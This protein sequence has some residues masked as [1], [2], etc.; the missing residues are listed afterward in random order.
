MAQVP[1]VTHYE[2]LD[3]PV[4]ADA[5]E[6]KKAYQKS[7]RSSHPD[8]GGSAGL[9]RLVKEAY[10]VLSDR[11][12]AP[13]MTAPSRRTPPEVP[14]TRRPSRN[15]R[16][17]SSARNPRSR[18]V[19]RRSPNPSRSPSRIRR[20]EPWKC[21]RLPP[22]EAVRPSSSAS[23]GG[24][25]ERRQKGP[26]PRS[27]VDRHLAPDLPDRRLPGNL[28]HGVRARLDVVEE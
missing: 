13:R 14:E 12:A 11:A 6:I 7:V 28:S 23:A 5:T 24:A 27:P 20:S 16:G 8:V 15:R 9:F 10:E 1:T 19:N 4:T 3:V 17:R 21:R 22:P 26:S 2:V 18:N 25:S